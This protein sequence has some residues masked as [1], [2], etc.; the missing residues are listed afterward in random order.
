MIYKNLEIHNVEQIFDDGEGATWCRVPSNVYDALEMGKR[1]AGNTT[2]VELRFVMKS[3]EV[4]LRMAV[5]NDIVDC[6]CHVFRGSVQGGWDDHEACKFIGKQPTDIIIK[7]SKNS[8]FLRRVSD[9]CGY[10]FD[11]EVIRVIFDRGYA[12]LIDVIGDIEPPKPEQ[13][14]KKT[15]LT[16][17]SSIT[18]G[19]NSMKMSHAWASVLAH[20]LNTDLRN[21]GMPGSCAMEPEYADHIASLGEAGKWNVATLELGINVLGWSEDKA[22]KRA[23]NTVFQVAGRN[24]SKPVYVISPFYCFEDFN[25]GDRA[26]MW[27]RTVERACRELDLPN[28]V[29]INGLDLLGDISLISADEVHPNIYGV[30]QIADRLTKIIAGRGGF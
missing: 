15:L 4:C 20:N 12:K 7:R 11:P 13:L 30:R 21:L 3:D 27:R 9:E 26:A 22:Y 28:V 16:Y 29:Y 8:E 14:P 6:V 17:G 23:K 2:G 24:P 25:G 5:A 10:C 1:Q 18:H 19:S